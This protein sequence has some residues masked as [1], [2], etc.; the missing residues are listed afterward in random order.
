LFFS[1]FL[2]FNFLKAAELKNVEVS[3]TALGSPSFL[4]ITGEA[5]KLEYVVATVK[6]GEKFDVFEFP[7]KELSTGIDLRDEHMKEKYLDVKEYPTAQLKFRQQDKSVL[8]FEDKKT[9]EGTLSLHGQTKA[10][11]IEAQKKGKR[12]QAHYE[13]KLS[14][15][16]IKIPEW[17]G[18]T[19][20]DKVSVQTSFDL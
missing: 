4:R 8:A 14:D 13:I 5:S 3:F 12:V 6:G 16:G 20:A 7:L 10:I 15:F 18:I 17:A 9:L 2:F 19:V 1:F 11:L